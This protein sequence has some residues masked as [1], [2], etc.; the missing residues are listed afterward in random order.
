[1]QTSAVRVAVVSDSW[2]VRE[3]VA[4]V[5]CASPE[6]QMLAVADRDLGSL[7]AES[8]H[9]VL[10]TA[11]AGRPDIRLLVR[12]VRS[13][14]PDVKVII[15]NVDPANEGIM[16]LMNAGVSGFLL[17]D[18]TSDE[19]VTTIREVGKG[20]HVLPPN[21]TGLLFAQLAERLGGSD[22]PH[23]TPGERRVIELIG[24]GYGNVE[25]ARQLG[26]S[27]H[28]VRSHVHNM[29]EKLGVHTRLQ[30]AAYLFGRCTPAAKPPTP[31]PAR[32][33]SSTPA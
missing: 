23:L 4:A 31:A 12:R 16:E 10:M 21:M 19:F 33:R 15:M 7:A 17:K 29:M 22:G 3:A 24:N 11:G 25:I 1:V 28:T 2:I 20:R 8:P 14:M 6:V 5:L 9:I 26:R 18:A 27:V 32:R 13:D 30:L